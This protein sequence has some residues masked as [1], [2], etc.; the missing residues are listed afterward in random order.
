MEEVVTKSK[1]WPCKKNHLYNVKDMWTHYKRM[2]WVKFH[3]NDRDPKWKPQLTYKQYKA[4]IQEMYE[5]IEDRVF[6]NKPVTIKNFGTLYIQKY[7]AHNRLIGPK[8]NIEL[9]KRLKMPFKRK[10]FYRL[11]W[12]KTQCNIQNSQYYVFNLIRGVGGRGKERIKSK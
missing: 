12:D 10:Y 8:S 9:Q 1:A 3:E 7:K 11:I 2:C 4:I 5:N 6:S